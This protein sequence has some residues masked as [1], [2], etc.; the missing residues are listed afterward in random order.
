MKFV[1]CPFE[2]LPE[3]NDSGV[4]V[5]V[6]TSSGNCKGK[7]L[8]LYDFWREVQLLTVTANIPPSLKNISDYNK[9]K[10]RSPKNGAM[11]TQ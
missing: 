5:N 3:L 2:V 11:T 10:S 7:S 9:D 6:K 8:G 1:A 4:E